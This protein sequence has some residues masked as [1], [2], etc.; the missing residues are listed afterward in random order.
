MT[1]S[2]AE[3]LDSAPCGVFSIDVASGDILYANAAAARITALS[4]DDLV[5]TAVTDLFSPEFAPVLRELLAAATSSDSDSPIGVTAQLTGAPASGSQTAV[6]MLA[7]SLRAVSGA[8]TVTMTLHNETERR[9]REQHLMDARIYA[10]AAQDDA[11]AALDRS[12]DAL[13]A[14]E[15]ARKLA[16]AEKTQVQILASTLQR[17]LLPPILSAPTGMQVAAHY[18]PASIDEVGGDFYDVFPL[19]NAT[20]GFFLG[21]VSGKGAGAAAVTSL[22]RYTLRAAAV[23]DRDPI[24]VLENLNTVLHHEFHGDDPRFCTVVFGTVAPGPDGAVV[25]LASGGHPPALRIAHDGVV[26]FVDT[27]G[28]QLVGALTE[29]HFASA[30][31]T[32]QPGDVLA[33]YTDGLTEAIVGPGRTRFDDDGS[34]H[35]FAAERG[36]TSAAKI[37]DDLT[38]LLAS[39]GD[40]LQDDVALLAFEVPPIDTD[41]GSDP[42]GS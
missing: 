29:P 23:F 4:R 26:E 28:G 33:F 22:T 38:E 7:N 18:H 30:T 17:T 14:S 19:D 32:M 5:G 9:V 8:T 16:E 37:V 34:L 24:A 25:H 3:L 2:A 12:Q 35:A 20:W 10:E 41:S 15:E 13:G 42:T 21:D 31:V 11:E 1:A 40:G 6:S 39:F 36:R 27:T